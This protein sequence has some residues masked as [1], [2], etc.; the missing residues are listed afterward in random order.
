MDT[1]RLTQFINEGRLL[2]GKWRGTDDRGRETACLLAALAPE[3]GRDESVASCPADVMPA[4]LA[5][6]TPW[7]DDDGTDEAWPAMV[8]R[9]AAVAAR[10]HVLDAVAWQRV[11]WRV[12]VAI[13]TEAMRHTDDARVLAAC[14][15]VI[16]VYVDAIA[17]GV[18]DESR[19]AAAESA[20]ASVAWSVAWSAANSAASAVARAAWR[21]AESAA[22]SAAKSAAVRAAYSAATSAAVRAAYSAAT[23]AAKRA[24]VDRLTAAILGAIEAACDE[25][26]AA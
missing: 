2:R 22:Y 3:C 17:T 9:Y 23:R 6:L 8:R 5:H 26:E 1:T 11:E 13:V 18:V 20:A 12:H 10:W 21:A 7:M 16:D 19:R 14:Q 24:T 15:G 4:W 25:A